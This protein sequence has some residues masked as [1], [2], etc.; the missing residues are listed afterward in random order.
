MPVALRAH[1]GQSVRVSDAQDLRALTA[2]D[3]PWMADVMVERRAVYAAMSPVF[4]R[5][6]ANARQVH[7]PHLAS[8]V[9]NERYVGIGTGRGFVLGELQAAGSPPWWPEAPLGFVDDFAVVADDAWM[10]DGRRLLLAAWSLLRERGAEALRVVTARRD[11]AKVAMLESLG[12]TIG[13]SWWVRAGDASVSGA[14]AFGPISAY[15]I[16]ALVIPAPPVYDPG[17]PVLLVTALVS[18]NDVGTVPQLAAEHGAVL[19]IVPAKPTTPE[20]AEA[21]R[22]AGFDETSRYYVGQPGASYG[23]DFGAVVSS[24]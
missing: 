4:W 15:G 13:E 12:L 18:P 2:D 19:A 23:D 8:C 16:E 10:S 9:A 3:A 24:T 1:R 7:E 21:A 5:P 22:A 11:D 17:G 14:P 6:A 20:M